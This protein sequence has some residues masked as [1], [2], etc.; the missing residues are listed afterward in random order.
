MSGALTRL[1]QLFARLRSE[2]TMLQP[3]IVNG[4]R[5]LAKDYADAVRI[6]TES[7]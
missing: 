7:Q 4:M 5:V 2:G 3:F 6:A 1:R